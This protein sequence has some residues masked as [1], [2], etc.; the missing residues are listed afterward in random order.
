VAYDFGVIGGCEESREV[1]IKAWTY[2]SEEFRTERTAYDILSASSMK[3][4]PSLIE[5][6]MDPGRDIYAL[7]L[8]KLG[9]SLQELCNLMSPNIRFD[10][11]MTLALAIQMVRDIFL[12]RKM[13]LLLIL[14]L[15]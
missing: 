1:I 8:E 12:V 4:C 6:R 5:T 11:K 3:G 2:F 13:Y 10:E 9:P 7:V 15:R 14:L